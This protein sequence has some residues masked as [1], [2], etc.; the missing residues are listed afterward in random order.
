MTADVV[1]RVERAVFGAYDQ[2]AFAQHVADEEIAGIR[3]LLFA[4]YAEPIPE[5]IRSF[6]RSKTSGDRYDDPGRLRSRPYAGP[7]TSVLM[8]CS[9]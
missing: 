4:P 6:S 9:S 3:D 7:A 2:Y 1:E 8:P 5:K